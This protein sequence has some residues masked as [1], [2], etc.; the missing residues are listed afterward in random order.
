MTASSLDQIAHQHFL[1]SHGFTKA[2]KSLDFTEALSSLD[3]RDVA[4]KKL[5]ESGWN[6]YE[7]GANALGLKT[8]HFRE[9]VKEGI[10]SLGVGMPSVCNESK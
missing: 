8:S 7:I 5:V 6:E 1:S 4:V 2:M 9:L 3:K 10:Y